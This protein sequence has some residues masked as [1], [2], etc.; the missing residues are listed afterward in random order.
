MRESLHWCRVVLTVG[1]LGMILG[2]CGGGGSATRSVEIVPVP[3]PVFEASKREFETSPEYEVDFDTCPPPNVCRTRVTGRDVHLRRINAAA[4]YARGATGMGEKLLVVD[5]GISTSHRE[6]AG[7]QKV[8]AGP[9]HP[10]DEFPECFITLFFPRDPCDEEHGSAVTAVAVGN[11]DRA[12]LVPFN[13]HGVAFDASAHFVDRDMFG[14]DFR[15]FPGLYFHVR[16]SDYTD[17]IMQRDARFF[18]RIIDV[19]QMQGASVINISANRHGAISEYDAVAIQTPLTPAVTALAQAD[20]EAADKIMIVW[21]AGNAGGAETLDLDTFERGGPV[22]FD[23]PEIYGGLPAY[24]PALRGHVLAVVAL[25]QDGVI[26]DYS[27]HC[28]IAKSF[29]L[30]AP[31]TNIVSALFIED[32]SYVVVS[33]T[34]FATPIVSGSLLLLRQ[35]FRGQLGNTEVVARLLATADKTGIYADSDIYGA[36]LVDLDAATR[37]DGQTVLFTGTSLN[38]PA[39]AEALSSLNAGAAFGDSLARGLANLEIAAFD[40]LDAPFFRPLS[41]YLRAPAAVHARLEDRLW[42]LGANTRNS[43]VWEQPGAELRIRFEQAA[44][45]RQAGG[46]RAYHEAGATFGQTLGALSFAGQVGGKPVF[47][48]FRQHPGWRL[49]LRGAGIVTPGTFSDDSAFAS[50]YLAFARN[51]GS[52]GLTWPLATGSLRA[53]AFRGGAQWGERRDPDTSHAL[54]AVLEYQFT[55]RVRAGAASGLALQVGWLREPKRLMGSRTQGA[56]GALNGGTGFAGMSAH[57]RINSRWSVFAATHLGWSH[58]QV[59]GQGLLQ[60]VSPLVSSAFSVGITGG[61]F[62]RRDDRVSLRVSQPLRVEAGHAAFRWAAGRT[63]DRQVRLREATLNLAPS[64]RQLDVE[65]AYALPVGATGPGGQPTGAL[66][67]AALASHHP[68][69]SR[70]ATEY[71]LLF[72][73]QQTF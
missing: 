4:A 49:G 40:A 11:R 5:S 10:G 14:P 35:Y 68:N 30:A 34:S 8:T 29:C 12:E 45:P 54:G 61:E 9:L 63:R 72:R 7:A 62:W 31:G 66:N 59:A 33:G 48:G 53:V 47:F 32:M 60:D 67:L 70:T 17:E 23:S 73:Y 25:D 39:V 52:A 2:G 41:A 3:D 57:A 42:T 21:S 1:A 28:G 43:L 6:F 26:A 71:A 18:G 65:L 19:A 46:S 16:L 56:F 24:F 38:G 27:N 44:D 15:G 51:G 50:P 36:G 13:M 20:T 69:H 64:A 58:P 55:G 37:P 22:R